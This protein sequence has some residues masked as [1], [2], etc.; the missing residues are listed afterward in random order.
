MRA[1]CVAIL[2]LAL[3]LEGSARQTTAARDRRER[4]W[5]AANV[6]VAKLE[7]FDYDAATAAFRNALRIDPAFAAAQLNLAIALYYGGHPDDARA[8]ARAAAA[9]LTGAPQP[10]Y[11]LGL[12]ARALNQLPDAADLFKRVSAIDPADAGAKVNLGQVQLQLQKFDEAVAAFQEALALEPYNA[13]AAY[14]LAQALL[15]GGKDEA[16]R[17][18]M[19]RFQTLRDRP[20]AVTYAQGYLQQG[21]YAEAIVSTGAEPELVDEA[22]PRVTFADATRRNPAAVPPLVSFTLLDVDGDGDQDILEVGASALRLKRNDGGRFTDITS[23]VGLDRLAL[24]TDGLAAVAGDYDNDG[25]ADLFLLCTGGDY[26]LHQRADGKFEDVTRPSG[27]PPG[28]VARAAAFADVDHDGDLDIVVA[29]SGASSHLLR[30]NGNG[31][32]TDIAGAAGIGGVKGVG[33]GIV[34]TDFDNRRDIDLLVAYADRPP[35]LFQNMRDGSFK[36]VA[37]AADLGSVT[38]ATAVAAGDINKDG[39]TDFFFARRRGPGAFAM[40]DGR[41][42]FAI[43]EALP[44]TADATFAILLDYDNDG[45]LDLLTGG[46]GVGAHLLRNL[47]HRWVDVT[48]EAGLPALPARA[49]LSVQVA[50][51]DNDGDSDIL[52]AAT[53]D[54]SVRVWRND[55]GSRNAAVRVQLAARVSNRS[56]VGAKVELRA[57]ALRGKL[58]TSAAIPAIAPADLLFGLGHRTA[59][60]TVRVLWPSGVLQAELAERAMKIAELDRKP[61]SCPFLF[62]WNGTRFEFVTD[63]LGGGEMGDWLAPGEWNTPDPDEYVRIRGDQLRARDGKYELR[64]TNELEEAMFLDRV[65]L[66]AVDHPR[67][68]EVHPNEGLHGG[69]RQPFVLHAAR[70]PRPPLRVHED[71]IVR[72]R[73]GGYAEP[74]ALTLDVGGSGERALLLLTGWTEYAFSSDNVAAAQAGLVLHPPSLQVRDGSGAWQTA[75]EDLG[76]PVGRPQ[77]IAVDLT[78]R[79]RGPSREVRI[80][81]NMPIHWERILVDTSDALE[82][83]APV[84]ADAVAATL[85]S[86]GFSAELSSEGGRPPRYDYSRVSTMSPWKAIPGRYTRYGDVKTLLCAADD[87]FV[88][89]APGDEIAV[90]FDVAAFPPLR[91]GLVRTFLLYADGFS[92]EMNIRSATPDSLGPLP[93]HAMRHY[94]YGPDERY[95][96]SAAH[97]AYLDRYNTRLVAAPVPSLDQ[98]VASLKR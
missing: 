83:P 14:G 60:D 87:M 75:I 61:S 39:F 41:G 38:G 68:V 5:R 54:E 2:C 33:V 26:L 3:G 80:V 12:I 24:S 81:T 9:A 8:P 88:V 30:N 91:D 67:D 97:R 89:A 35:A 43:S 95:P 78:G 13:T 23:A 42:K 72:T 70:S 19:Q 55:G 7:Q 11:I 52:V 53:G 34:A 94:P 22:T 85:R 65:Q 46:P 57:G 25:R 79:F 58:E 74:H 28:L 17:E 40:S 71:P 1:L 62:T 50:D 66:V 76:F 63:F 27:V 45:L 77:T 90:S 73:F 96:D 49:S 21:R 86:R 82:A 20:Y 16:G 6:G 56:A 59:A 32:F 51:I 36:D 84:R 48:K 29:G 92:K 93:F 31:T 44:V 18:A 10:P 15:R 98:A 47:G 4:A 64:I 69:P 37:S